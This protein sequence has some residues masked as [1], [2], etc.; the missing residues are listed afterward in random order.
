MKDLADI[1]SDCWRNGN[2]HSSGRGRSVWQVYVKDVL[3]HDNFV[4]MHFCT[5]YNPLVLD[6]LKGLFGLV[7]VEF[8]VNRLEDEQ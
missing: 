2:N 3:S 6:I 7:D 1:I 4:W 5:V 8:K